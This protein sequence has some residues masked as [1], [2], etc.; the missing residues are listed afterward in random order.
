MASPTTQYKYLERDPKSS[1]KQ[2][3]IKGRSIR[4]RTL[5][6]MYMS[7]EEPRTVKEIAEDYNLPIEA[8]EEAIAYCKSNPPEIEEDFRRTEMIMEL[9]GMND[10]NYKFHPN[11]RSLTDEDRAAIR[12]AST[13]I[14]RTRC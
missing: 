1:Y 9:S 3:S 8:V 4:A 11:P 6:G 13:R 7:A 10:P 14:L 12:Q 5:Y 2:L